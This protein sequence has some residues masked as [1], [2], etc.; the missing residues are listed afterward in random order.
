MGNL[1]ITIFILDWIRL[2]ISISSIQ[3]SEEP[4]IEPSPKA[5]ALQCK[6]LINDH[7]DNILRN[8]PGQ[9]RAII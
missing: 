7:Q 4:E 2:Q 5:P 9:F 3:N 6:T 1:R 8:A